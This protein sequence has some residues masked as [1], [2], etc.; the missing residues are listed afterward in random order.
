[1]CGTEMGLPNEWGNTREAK[2]DRSWDTKASGFRKI[3]GRR[4]SYIILRF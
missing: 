3:V 2:R 1:M 4:E